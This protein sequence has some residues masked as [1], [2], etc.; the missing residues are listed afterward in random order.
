MENETSLRP[1]P[2]ARS[3]EEAAAAA[4]TPPRAHE[5]VEEFARLDPEGQA[6]LLTRVDEA[7]ARAVLHEA[8]RG[9]V[10]RL[11]RRMQP[12]AA[13]AVW[14]LLPSDDRVE[15][16]RHLPRELRERFLDTLGAGDRAVA[17]SLL[18]MPQSTAGGRMSPNFVSLPE[19][20]TIEEALRIV[21]GSAQAE[22][23][24]YLYV[25]DARGRLR[26]TLSVRRLLT[27]PPGARVRDLMTPDPLRVRVEAR[28]EEGARLLE[29]HRFLAL[30]VVDAEDRILGILSADDAREAV[31]GAVERAVFEV[32]GVA[33]AEDVATPAW[34]AAMLR[35]PWL[36]V[37]VASGL[38]CAW[39]SGVFQ[40]TLLEAIVVA[41][42]VPL[43]LALGESVAAQTTA[44]VEKRFLGGLPGPRRRRTLAKEATVGLV[45]GLAIGGIVGLA[46][47][48]W[49]GEARFGW[50]LGG[51]VALALTWASVLGTAIPL[52]LHGSRI[53]PAVASGPVVLA[54]T[55]VSTLAIYFSLAEA[56]LRPAP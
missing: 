35:M 47:G 26:G 11:L 16:V 36:L 32:T 9:A 19:S 18:A 2:S 30:P 39:L 45:A 46:A 40:R 42:F 22:S 14:R 29:T 20:A 48:A 13:A 21:R 15:I 27:A 31:R 17:E 10:A 50:A 52:L 12:G 24:F 54:L 23:V 4:P 51:S 43:V 25:V 28:I 3:R 1:E 53:D 41:G 33:P 55:D 37:T 6:A 34:K 38:G 44:V 56:L 49:T 7:T 8:E 5:A